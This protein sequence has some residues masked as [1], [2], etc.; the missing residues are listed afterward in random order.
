M[1]L[2]G[3]TVRGNV[4]RWSHKRIGSKVFATQKRRHKAEKILPASV[5]IRMLCE[6]KVHDSV[7]IEGSR[8]K[9]LG[10]VPLSRIRPHKITRE[11]RTAQSK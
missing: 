8:K 11:V 1:F 9:M 4:R 6:G 10:E 3:K 2:G 5:H 7:N